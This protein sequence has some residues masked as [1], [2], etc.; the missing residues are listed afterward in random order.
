MVFFG[1]KIFISLRCA[2]SGHYI[3]LQKQF[4]RHK[5]LSEYL[6]LPMSE[7]EIFF[8]QI[9]WEKNDF[10]EK[11]WYVPLYMYDWLI[12][13]FF[14]S[15]KCGRQWPPIIQDVIAL[16]YLYKDSS[17]LKLLSSRKQNT[18]SLLLTVYKNMS[19]LSKL[20]EARDLLA[21]RLL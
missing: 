4:L 15:T 3:F 5:V 17:K 18:L 6:F 12:T 1:V 7:T 2:L 14:V 8:H 20:L 10:P 21:P 19:G 16:K 13:P 9:C 11:P